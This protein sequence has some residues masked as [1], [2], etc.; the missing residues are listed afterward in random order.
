LRA[1]VARLAGKM[2]ARAGRMPALP[3]T[4]LMAEVWG[5]GTG[6]G[7]QRRVDCGEGGV[8]TSAAGGGPET[9]AMKQLHFPVK[10]CT[11]QSCGEAA[12]QRFETPGFRGDLTVRIGV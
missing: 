6:R 11:G 9:F 2:P 5:W 8:D 12:R 7:S 1:G 4:T 3:G 10:R